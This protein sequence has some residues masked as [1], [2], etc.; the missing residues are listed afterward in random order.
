MGCLLGSRKYKYGI[1]KDTE[2]GGLGLRI[3]QICNFKK[4]IFKIIKKE[5]KEQ[6]WLTWHFQTL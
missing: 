4:G 1:G 6:R 3:V 2:V 5:S